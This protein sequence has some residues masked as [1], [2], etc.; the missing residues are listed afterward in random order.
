[1]IISF[2]SVKGGVAK[3]TSCC[4]IAYYFA[5]Q[6]Q[7][8]LIIDFDSQGGATHHLSSKFGKKFRASIYDVLRGE[9]KTEYAIHSYHKKLDIIPI[10][11]SFHEIAS[12]DF[13]GQ[14]KTILSELEGKYNFIFFD[15][16][17]SIYPGSTIPLFFSNYVIIPVDCPGGLSLLGLEAEIKIISELR[18]KG[19]AV[20]TL[21]VLPCFLDRTKIAKEVAEFLKKKYADLVLP[22]IRRNTE[23]SQA[24]S[25]GKTIFEY[26]SSSNGAKDYEKVAEVILKRTKE[27]TI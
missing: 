24:S 26:R 20:K 25:I 11:F 13:S 18:D 27:K 16:A 2:S 1:M 10:S 17:P 19:S 14:L 8:S 15:L 7:K 3:T 9:C 21:G 5:C 4:N 12:K 6:G 22:A 23:I